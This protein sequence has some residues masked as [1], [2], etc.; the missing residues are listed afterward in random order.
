MVRSHDWFLIRFDGCVQTSCK[1]FITCNDHNGYLIDRTP[2]P[3]VTRRLALR[4]SKVLRAQAFR[5]R[6]A[7]PLTVEQLKK[8]G[9]GPAYTARREFE[10]QL[11]S[12][13]ANSQ[14]L[15]VQ[16]IIDED[17][18]ENKTFEGGYQAL[19]QWFRQRAKCD[20]CLVPLQ[21]SYGR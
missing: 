5:C 16:W 9:T 19:V 18:A 3:Q 20:T 14:Q 15:V 1:V 17:P 8:I 12:E 10:A 2:T 13:Q 6:E 4:C 11:R 21:R 7:V